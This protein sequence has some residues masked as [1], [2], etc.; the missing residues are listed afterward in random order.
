MN[1]GYQQ[2]RLARDVRFDGQFFVAVKTTKIFCRPI[3]PAKLPLEKNVEYFQLAQ[4]AMYFGYR[5]CLRCRPD[6]APHSYA[7]QGVNTTVERAMRLLRQFHQLSMEQISHKLGISP[8]YFR[9][10]FQ[11]H[12]GMSPKQYQLFDKVLLAKQLLHQSAL[13]IEDIAQASGFASSRRLQ[14]QFKKVIG[15]TPQQIRHK[16]LVKN[17]M[18]NIKTAV[19]APYN[20]AVL[21]DFFAVRAISGIEK[22]SENSYA[23]TFH[24]DQQRGWFCATFVEQEQ[25]FD[26][27]IDLPKIEYLTPVVR[28]IERIFDTHTNSQTILQQL[29]KSGVPEDNLTSGLR[30]PGVWDLFEAGCRAILGQQISVKAAISLLTQLTNE[31]GENVLGRHYFP[32]PEAIA[33]SELS[34]LRIPNSRIKTLQ[35]FA[36][37][38]LNNPQGDVQNW[39]DIKGIGPWTIAYSKLRGLSSPDIWLDSDLVIK[40]QLQNHSV[41]P[42]IARPW[43]SY[44]TLQLWNMA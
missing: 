17:K 22:I 32:S 19:R 28:N 12:I 33:N 44:L 25:C 26:L 8:R 2:A 11:Q 7:W 23:R 29:R 36:T 40:K 4:Q 6:S 21:R 15:L 5:P 3:C 34:F 43:R 14:Y 35:A 41:D 38:I 13:P 42:D 27:Q 10:L 16:K 30:L 9:L 18:L 31:L 24:I 37:Y 1:L 39:I 20:W